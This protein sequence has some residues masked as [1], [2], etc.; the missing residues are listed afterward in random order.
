MKDEKPE[1]TNPFSTSIY[2]EELLRRGVTIWSE[3]EGAWRQIPVALSPTTID[4]GQWSALHQDAQFVISSFPKAM[5]WLQVSAQ[6]DEAMSKF[7]DQMLSGLS[8]HEVDAAKRSPNKFW[9]H[10]SIRLDLFWHFGEWKIIEAN[11]TIPA[12]QAYSD[13]VLESWISAG[14]STE[15]RSKNMEQ[16]LH[17]LLSL[18]RS[19]GGAS[20]RP[21]IAILHRPGDSQ[22]G[23]LKWLE[24]RWS[25]LGF[26]SVLVT[27][28]HL[29]RRG[30]LWFAHARPCDLVYRHIFASRL[31]N[32]E[33][34]QA[35]TE[36]LETHIYNPISA[37]Y[38]S[39]AFF[40]I[41]SYLAADEEL[42]DA[43]GIS[44]DEARAIE[45]RVPWCRVIGGSFAGVSAENI[46]RRL[47][48]VV[49]K[50]S[51]GYGGHSVLLGETWFS[52]ETQVKLR[53][54]TGLKS[55]VD[56][57]S[58][59]NWTESDDSLWVV[60]E[61]M[62]GLRRHTKVMTA[63]GVEDWNAWFD[64]SIFVNSPDGQICHGGV[65]RVAESPIV[66]IGTGGGL[67]PL[68]IG[69]P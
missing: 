16:L 43:S 51:I 31:T 33:I 7:F 55:V 4:S 12:M 3:P 28:H 19:H 36:S 60:Q 34:L 14:G 53:T 50:R 62:S 1:I 56:L 68:I 54:L 38:E 67:A 15:Y 63:R 20:S 41:L 2:L 40:A 25:E 23:E 69:T 42:C 21:R 10:A 45:R 17:S 13:N 52:E 6:K 49:I 35:L 29:E 48:N 58:F 66:N 64:A 44:K 57:K 37:H 22:L 65:S 46:A 59:L 5:R 47:E 9:G 30:D 61:R 8:R 32:E 24:K 26:E 18:Y 39:K 11:C 27:P